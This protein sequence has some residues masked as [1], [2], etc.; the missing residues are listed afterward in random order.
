MPL[1]YRL[2]RLFAR[3]I[4]HAW[5]RVERVGE[6]FPEEGPLI[7]V[8]N[9]TG[10]L[11]DVALVIDQAPRPVRFLS[12][13]KI[14]SIPVL[15]G[16]A[17]CVQAIPVYRK[18]DQVPTELNQESFEA[19][20]AALRA[21][22]VIGAFPEGESKTAWRL[23]LPLKTGVAR[24]A[25][26]AEASAEWKVGVRILPVGVHYADRDRFRSRVEL[27][28]GHPFGVEHLR[29][30]YA[31]DERA[32]VPAL[33]DEVAR[34]LRE[35]SLQVEED[36]D[37]PALSLARRAWHEPGGVH[38]H[39]L[40]RL[41]DALASE[42]LRDPAIAQE[43][44]ARIAALGAALEEAQL[45]PAELSAS[46][47][48]G[49][50]LGF[51]GWLG[52]T[53]A[54][55]VWLPPVLAARAAARRGAPEDKFVTVTALTTLPFGLLWLI[56]I[57]CALGSWVGLLPALLV[58]LILA[59]TAPLVPRACD[60]RRD[61]RRR[62]RRRR[63]GPLGAE[64]AAILAGLGELARTAKID[65]VAEEDPDASIPADRRAPSPIRL[66]PKDGGRP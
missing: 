43:R 27:R 52:A 55:L 26:G 66:H 10:G 15:G 14:F 35:V 38:H 40:Q 56:L 25:L 3:V 4:L 24:M 1:R 22:Q 31:L 61:W 53:G 41:A 64:L 33:I 32:A 57:G 20:F 62:V 18:K 12:K 34:G 54:A 45:C 30:A 28:I 17:R 8:G 6:P 48:G 7:V 11:I 63:A 49:A 59:L 2:A 37:L 47:R 65:V 51:L 60:A 29:E 5:Y 42:H 19:V 46:E 39:H 13:F 23:R 58:P 44:S 9:H 50:A 21:G 36:A 16:L